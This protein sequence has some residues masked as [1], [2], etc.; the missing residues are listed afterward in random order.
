MV[1][2]SGGEEET[3]GEEVTYPRL[4]GWGLPLLR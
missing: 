4:Q 2:G 1:G 3:L